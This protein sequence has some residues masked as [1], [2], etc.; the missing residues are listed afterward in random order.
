MWYLT[1]CF[2]CCCSGFWPLMWSLVVAFVVVSVVVMLWSLLWSLCSGPC[3]GPLFWSLLWFCYGLCVVVLVVLIV[4]LVSGSCC[5]LLLCSLSLFFLLVP[6]VVP[7]SGLLCDPHCLSCVWSLLWPPCCCFPRRGSCC[8]PWVWSLVVGLV[9]FSVVVLVV[10][11]V[12]V[13]VLGLVVVLV[14]HVVVF[15]CASCCVLVVIP[16]AVLVF[17]SSNCSNGTVALLWLWWLTIN[18]QTLWVDVVSKS[19]SEF[20]A[21]HTNAIYLNLF[22]EECHAKCVLRFAAPF[23][24]ADAAQLFHPIAF[25]FILMRTS[26][27]SEFHPK[28]NRWNDWICHKLDI[29]MTHFRKIPPGCRRRQTTKSNLDFAPWWNSLCVWIVHRCVLIVGS[30]SR[31]FKLAAALQNNFFLSNITPSSRKLS[32]MC[33]LVLLGFVAGLILLTHRWL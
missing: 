6:V 17:L 32:L 2:D 29:V 33:G 28:P 14:V 27:D 21:A 7:C 10:A 8:G 25:Q 20:C 19:V 13:P 22:W 23:C 31:L 24:E 3:C 18:I 11:P 4:V 16:F 12:V 9:L 26:I 1:S 5:G 30:P 15:I